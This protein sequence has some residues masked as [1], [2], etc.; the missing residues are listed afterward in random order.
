MQ[1]QKIKNFINS[2]KYGDDLYTLDGKGATACGAVVG[3]PEN[4]GSN[5]GKSR[6]H[7]CTESRR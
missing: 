4:L 6:F 5:F 7:V 2:K 1:R 3:L